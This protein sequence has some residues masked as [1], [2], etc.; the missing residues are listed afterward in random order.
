MGS[1]KIIFLLI[2]VEIGT[3]IAMGQMVVKPLMVVV[4]DQHQMIA[5]C[6]SKL[7]RDEFCE[8]VA[9]PKVKK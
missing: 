1:F 7:A 3:M 4:K 9:I 8:I 5:D 6:E 2:V